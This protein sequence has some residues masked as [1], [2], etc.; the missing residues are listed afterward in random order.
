MRTTLRI[1]G[2]LLGIG[3]ALLA[4]YLPAMAWVTFVDAEADWVKTH[5]LSFWGN[6]GLWGMILIPMLLFGGLSY[7]FL[8]YAFRKPRPS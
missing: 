1:A 7:A 3:A 2:A 6:L 4:L 5:P 8:R